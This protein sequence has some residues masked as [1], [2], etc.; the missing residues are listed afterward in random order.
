VLFAPLSELYGR[1]ISVLVPMFIFV[2]FSAA[3]ATAEN[4]QTIFIVRDLTI[5]VESDY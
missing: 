3:T 4:L 5:F 2:C 1:K